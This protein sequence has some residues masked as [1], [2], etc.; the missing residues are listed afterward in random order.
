MQKVSCSGFYRAADRPFVPHSFDF[1]SF[2][3]HADEGGAH[4]GR[5]AARMAL[6][7]GP[8]TST[9]ANWKVMARAPLVINWFATHGEA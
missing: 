1:E 4:N 8:V 9:S 5:I 2:Q 3:R 6:T 7:I